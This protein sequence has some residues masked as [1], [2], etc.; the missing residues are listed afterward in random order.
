M[1]V[2]DTTTDQGKVI[3]ELF[4]SPALPHVVVIDKNQKQQIFRTSQKLSNEELA[5]VLEDHK[6]GVVKVSAPKVTTSAFCSTHSPPGIARRAS[7]SSTAGAS[8]SIFST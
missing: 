4:Q 6:E 8:S 7:S 2:I 3:H 1:A 5:N